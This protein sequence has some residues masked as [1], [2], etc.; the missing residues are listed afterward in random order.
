MY[1]DDYRRAGFPMLP[2]VEP[3]GV[4]TGRQALLYAL[5]LV[6][7][8]LVPAVVGVAGVAYF[9]LALALGGAFLVLSARFAR[10]RSEA[11]ARALFYGSLLYLPLIW[12]AMILD[13]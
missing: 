6:P 2:V 3:D 8:S 1:R 12:A 5:A 7:V 10:V 11:R 13:H 9:W 4:R